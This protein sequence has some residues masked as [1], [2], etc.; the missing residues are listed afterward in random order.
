MPT[1]F[2]QGGFDVRVRPR[3]H[4]PPHVHI[5]Y[6]REEVVINLGIGIDE[7][8]I[9]ENRGMRRVNIRRAMD[10]VTANNSKF[11]IEWRRFHP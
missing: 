6:G 7:A 4:H 10:I 11:L 5:L 8:H 9:R 1:I 2:R 3:D